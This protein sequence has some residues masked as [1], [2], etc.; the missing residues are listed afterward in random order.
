L[1]DVDYELAISTVDQKKSAKLC[2]D[3]NFAG[4]PKPTTGVDG[5]GGG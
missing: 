3:G 5:S 1:Q 2:A 4:F